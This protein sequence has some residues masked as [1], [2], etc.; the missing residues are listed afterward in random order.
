[1][2]RLR[3]GT[4]YGVVSLSIV[5]EWH[6]HPFYRGAGFPRAGGGKSHLGRAEPLLCQRE[7]SWQALSM[8][9]E[10]HGL[11]RAECQATACGCAISRRDCLSARLQTTCA[12]SRGAHAYCTR[13]MGS[14]G[15]AASIRYSLADP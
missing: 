11:S 8:N 12:S 9:Q 1:M 2:P 14:I 10:S 5:P 6:D 13:E 4:P 7:L 3:P 15:Q